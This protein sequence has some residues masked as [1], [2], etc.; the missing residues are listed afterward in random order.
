M[1]A[2]DRRAKSAHKAMA[3]YRQGNEPKEAAID[4]LADMLHW[5]DKHQVDLD[6]CLR[7]ARVHH[8]AEGGQ[9]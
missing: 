5:A 7:I 9:A 2:N 3:E 1:T 6:D 4:L 8:Q